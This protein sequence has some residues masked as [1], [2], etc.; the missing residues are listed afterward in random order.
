[1]SEKITFTN[2]KGLKLVG[3]LETAKTDKIV[4]LAH[5]FTSNKDRPKMVKTAEALSKEGYAV[6]RFDFTDSG[7]SDKAG[8]TVAGQLDDLQTAMEFARKKGYTKIALV[9]S[10][11]GGLLSILA[12]DKDVFTM[13]LIA[14]VT[15]AKTPSFLKDTKI[16]KEIEEKGYL[17]IK[18]G[19]FRVEKQYLE[20][21][22]SINQAEILSKVKCP[23]LI[24]HGDRDIDVPLE[25][26]KNAMKYLPNGSKLEIIKGADHDFKDELPQII[27]LAVSW[28]K[29]HL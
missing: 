6:L 12:Y 10:S 28:I 16:R 13:V 25:H 23:V 18:T 14:P 7:E 11:L 17:I 29:K 8:I 19:E 27:P 4:I 15:A 2:S 24:I 20:E 26:S 9:G 3:I 1:M 5:G 22:E 21:R